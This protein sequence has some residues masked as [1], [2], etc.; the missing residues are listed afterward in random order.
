MYH[1]VTGLLPPSRAPHLWLW[2]CTKAG[3]WTI[4]VTLMSSWLLCFTDVLVCAETAV[5]FLAAS[6][7]QCGHSSISG[8]HHTYS[9]Q[10]PSATACLSDSLLLCLSFTQVKV[11]SLP[12]CT[13]PVHAYAENS[14]HA[15]VCCARMQNLSCLSRA[16]RFS[17]LVSGDCARVWFEWS[18]S[19]V[20]NGVMF[21]EGF[22]PQFCSRNS[23]L[24]L[25]WVL[26]VCWLMV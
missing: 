15:S 8:Q 22:P 5:R 2:P 10:E 16:A 17:C 25:C 12:F 11:V 26:I 20:L 3:F 7:R 1:E 14:G 18:N 6:W 23:L 4:L 21:C 19:V 24:L 13:T 9:F